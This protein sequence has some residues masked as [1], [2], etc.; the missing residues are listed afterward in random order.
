MVKTDWTRRPY[1]NVFLCQIG[2]Q[3]THHDRTRQVEYR[4]SKYSRKMGK[5]PKHNTCQRLRGYFSSRHFVPLRYASTLQSLTPG[6]NAAPALPASQPA[7]KDRWPWQCN[8]TPISTAAAAVQRVAQSVTPIVV[9]AESE[10]HLGSL[11]V[12]LGHA[13]KPHMPR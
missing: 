3:D 9:E 13:R 1:S 10:A 12:P 7:S 11:T 6:R 5:V 4:K 2:C 8:E